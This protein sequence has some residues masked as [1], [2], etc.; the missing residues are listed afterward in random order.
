M[1]F[2]KAWWWLHGHPINMR[3]SATNP[4]SKYNTG[5]YQLDIDVH[6]EDTENNIVFLEFGSY[7]DF[8]EYGI[9][10]RM[11]DPRLDCGGKTFEEAIIN[12]AALVKE[13]YG[14]YERVS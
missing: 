8:D 9:Y 3:P 6:E 2:I 1:N 7:P 4:E 13:H 5:L 11:H 14:D 10:D 12:L